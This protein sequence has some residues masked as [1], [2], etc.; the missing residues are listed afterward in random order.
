MNPGMNKAV[1]FTFGDAERIAQ[2]V[3]KSERERRGR[4]PSSLPRAAGSGGGG[5]SGGGVEF[6]TFAG[7]W[8]KGT[9]KTVTLLPGTATASAYNSLSNVAGSGAGRNC[10]VSIF[11]GPGPSGEEDEYRLVSAECS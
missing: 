2:A 11:P 6:A 7:S 5:G 10:T 4:K 8:F 3:K 1:T 9:Y